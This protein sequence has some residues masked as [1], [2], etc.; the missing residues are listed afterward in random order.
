MSHNLDPLLILR[1]QNPV[2]D[3]SHLAVGPP[4][5]L[6]FEAERLV[7]ERGAL[8][9][10][11]PVRPFRL[12]HLLVHDLQGRVALSELVDFLVVQTEPRV[13]VRYPLREFAAVVVIVH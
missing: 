6:T 7:A 3:H 8:R 5:I 2:T 11:R 13:V 9:T 10:Q 1:L 12:G 4:L